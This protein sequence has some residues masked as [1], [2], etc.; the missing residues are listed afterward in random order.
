MS[1]ELGRITKTA[2]L[3]STCLGRFNRKIFSVD[4]SPDGTLFQVVTQGIVRDQYVVLS[5]GSTMQ[6]KTEAL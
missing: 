3:E 6:S 2:R 1:F 4:K 5:R